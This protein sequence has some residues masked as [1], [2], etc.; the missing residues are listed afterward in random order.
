MAPDEFNNII[1]QNL[2]TDNAACVQC[3]FNGVNPKDWNS[4]ESNY[5]LLRSYPKLTKTLTIIFFKTKDL[6]TLFSFEQISALLEIWRDYREG[7]CSQT[8][9]HPRLPEP[10]AVRDLLMDEIKFF[11]K[12]IQEK[13]RNIGRSVISNSVCLEFFGSKSITIILIITCYLSTPFLIANNSQSFEPCHL[14]EL[15]HSPHPSHLTR[16]HPHAVRPKVIIISDC[17]LV[18]YWRELLGVGWSRALNRLSYWDRRL[19]E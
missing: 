9:L 3:F 8:L 6:K 18:P 7:S 13:A 17:R 2:Q 4:T 14:Y 16:P 1:L 11:V 12:N 19:E 5:L 15:L 10:P